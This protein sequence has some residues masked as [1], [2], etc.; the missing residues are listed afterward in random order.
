MVEYQCKSL[1]LAK[2]KYIVN[3]FFIELFKLIYFLDFL[4]KSIG[5]ILNYLLWILIN[6]INR[7]SF[8][9]FIYNPL[10]FQN[11]RLEL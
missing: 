1:A 4:I 10:A 2:Q 3:I 7:Y 11:I 9:Y 5:L 6:F 8:C